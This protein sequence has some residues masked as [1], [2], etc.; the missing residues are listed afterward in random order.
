[1][2]SRR[3]CTST[4]GIRFAATE[5]IDIFD[6]WEAGYDAGWER[7]LMEGFLVQPI[8]TWEPLL[9]IRGYSF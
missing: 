6:T 2:L 1:M 8:R 9:R 5:I 4:N 3:T 7:Y